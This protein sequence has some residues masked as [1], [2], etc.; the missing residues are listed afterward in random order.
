M[1]SWTH[2]YCTING[3]SKLKCY[4][5]RA[6]CECR[7]LQI[8]GDSEGNF[9]DYTNPK[10]P[11][12]YDVHKKITFLTPLSTCIHMGR[13]PLVDVHTRAVKNCQ[14]TLPCKRYMYGRLNVY[15]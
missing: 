6:S 2:N 11:S 14:K 3:W 7:H 12:I 13:T 5:T 8:D 10:G 15:T 9:Y 1:F 4:W